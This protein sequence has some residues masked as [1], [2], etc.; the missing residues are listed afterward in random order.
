MTTKFEDRDLRQRD[1]VPISRLS[2]R[3]VEVV[4]VGGIGKQ[5]ALSLG[6]MG[7]PNLTLVDGDYVGPENLAVQGFQERHVDLENP[8]PKVDAVKEY[9]LSHNSEVNVE[10]K[11]YMFRKNDKH[12]TIVFC[13]VD[14]MAARKLIWESV[15]NNI[16]IFIDGRMLGLTMRVL[17]VFDPESAK[18]YQDPKNLFPDSEGSEGRCTEKSTIFT[19]NAVSAIMINNL[20]RWMRNRWTEKN[21]MMRPF[22]DVNYNL[23]TG[24]QFLFGDFDD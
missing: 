15:R 1:I 14:N 3:T 5:V 10:V 11:N 22:Q 13:C 6:M 17:T 2:N 16:E 4:G 9:I 7:V 19:A 8:I 18:H 12:G 20:V 24:R 23:I 21:F